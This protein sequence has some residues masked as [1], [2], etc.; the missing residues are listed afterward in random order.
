MP[1]KTASKKPA[2]KKKPRARAAT[3][4]SSVRTQPSDYQITLWTRGAAALRF[5]TTDRALYPIAVSWNRLLNADRERM[6]ESEWR[7]A[8]HQAVLELVDEAEIGVQRAVAFL[9]AAANAGVIQVEI[10]WI[11]ES[12]GYAA[13]VFPWE[14]MLAL[15]TKDLR[16]PQGKD[17]AVVRYLRKGTG[18]S[19]AVMNASGPPVFVV[20]S[21]AEKLGYDITSEHRVISDALETGMRMIK[22][23]SLQQLAEILRAEKP[24]IVHCVFATEEIDGQ[25]ASSPLTRGGEKPDYFNSENI[26]RAVA[27]HQPALAVF[28][29]C[30]SGRRLAPLAVAEGA[31]MAV[32]FHDY[33]VDAS[34]PAFFGAFYEAWQKA[35]N[36]LE[37]LQNGLRANGYQPRPRDLGVV[38]LWTDFDLLAATSGAVAPLAQQNVPP[39]LAA[40]AEKAVVVTCKPVKA[41]NYAMLQNKRG[42]IFTDFQVFKSK[43]GAMPPLEVT[44]TLDTGLDL[45]AR[46]HFFVPMPEEGARPIPL[47]DLVA[48]PLGA[49]ILR[50]RGETMMGTLEV[51]V[52]C[53]KNS[54]FHH[55]VSIQVPPCDEW[56]DNAEGR[57]YL[58][59]FVFPR[60]PAVRDIIT[61]AQPFLRAIAD[62][63]TAGFDG[64]QGSF[65]ADLAEASRQQVRAIWA[66]LQLTLRLDYVEP[67][68]SYSDAQRL[69][70]PEEVQRARRGT[71]IELALLLASCLEHIGIHPVIF[72]TKGH[73]FTG[74][75]ATEQ[76]RNEFQKIPNLLQF[77]QPL[78]AGNADAFGGGQTPNVE[79]WFLT[80]QQ[81]LSAIREQVRKGCLIPL[82]ATFLALQQPFQNA[83]VEATTTIEELRGARDD[84]DGMLDI[85]T[86]REK[87]ITPLS[88]LVQGIVA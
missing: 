53:Q 44:I 11:S 69:R 52:E 87:N 43:P 23:G 62:H 24:R 54:V 42:G 17:M 2:A 74:Y 75:W 47:M 70:V 21:Q 65:A 7:K 76:A 18:R 58:P 26:A 79:P 77:A 73:S 16:E 85:K 5:K 57:R 72:L 33:V 14:A 31:C 68:P 46:S 36:I 56:L 63:P 71:C 82:E 40:D 4:S 37:C 9:N 22:S 41:L 83:V 88:I 86:A 6:S 61:A 38:T 80:A 1:R 49:K 28:S 30:H 59:C 13:R 45:P 84:F 51:S 64:Y 34:I 20:S 81:H 27:A 66:A 15:A 32:G 60:D 48:M 25:E 19:A 50:Q 29:T 39:I 35:P 8:A 12:E 3:S 67:P 55:F 10:P 78:E